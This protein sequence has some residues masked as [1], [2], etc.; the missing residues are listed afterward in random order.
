MY[1]RE[2]MTHYRS[3]DDA[4]HHVPQHAR[5]AASLLHTP[6]IF[7]TNHASTDATFNANGMI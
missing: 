2:T 3:Q 1:S 4:S 5:M 6:F 7:D